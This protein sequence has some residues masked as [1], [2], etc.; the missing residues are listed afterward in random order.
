[1]YRNKEKDFSLRSLGG[2]FLNVIW[3]HYI[4]VNELKLAYLNQMFKNMFSIKEMIPTV[5]MY[6][7]TQKFSITIWV[8]A[9]CVFWIEKY[10]FFFFYA[11]F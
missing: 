5:S 1:M 7:I 6:Y 3:L 2:I 8:V 4:A 9:E 11:K 10:F